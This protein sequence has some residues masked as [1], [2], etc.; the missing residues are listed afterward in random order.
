MTQKKLSELMGIDAKAAEKMK[1]MLPT[2]E[3]AKVE[4][5]SSVVCQALEI[6][7]PV[8]WTD[9]EDIE[10][11]GQVLPVMVEKVIRADGMIVPYS[12]KYG[13]WLS[14]KT[15]AMGIMRMVPSDDVEDLVGKKFQIKVTTARYKQ[16][17]NRCYVV[18]EL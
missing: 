7:K 3:L 17:E 16:G 13:L 6:P 1:D 4:I 5:G 9:E 15:L 11:T 2:F 14:S 18:K 8:T 12:D 10:K